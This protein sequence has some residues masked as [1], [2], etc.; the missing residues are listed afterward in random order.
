MV[1]T[2]IFIVLAC[3]GISVLLSY[4]AP[5]KQGTLT[6]KPGP[7]FPDT[8]KAEL[9]RTVARILPFCPGMSRVGKELTFTNLETRGKSNS[10]GASE[11][12]DVRMTFTVPDIASIPAQWGKYDAPCEFAVEGDFLHIR[13]ASCQ[14]ICLG[15]QPDTP[16]EE[17]SVNLNPKAQN[18]Q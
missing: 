11:Q 4:C 12:P 17:L 7:G 16:V 1:R 9:G 6:L 8:Q 5:T 3:V 18:K 10:G 13:G 15:K 14:A 2:I